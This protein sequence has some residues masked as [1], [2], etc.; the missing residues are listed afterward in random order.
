VSAFRRIV[1]SP[2]G[3]I[4][5][6]A[7]ESGRLTELRFSPPPASGDESDADRT[8]GGGRA[9]GVLD[10]AARQ[11]EEYF[12]GR[13]RRF[14][15]PLA[16]RGTP[17]QC[18]VWDEVAAI[19]YGTTVGYGRIAAQLGRP[20]SA[21]AVGHANGHNPIAVVIPCHR[22][23]GPSGALTGYGGGLEAKRF[24]LELERGDGLTT[25]GVTP[26]RRRRCGPGLRTNET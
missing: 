2:I 4:G 20:N 9:S 24:L 15:L 26:D 1:D 10:R 5:L 6:G 13:R 16:P 23:V 22:V 18:Q 21:R 7:E 11:L 25:P 8:G 17:F 14:E 19:A 12:A 3:P